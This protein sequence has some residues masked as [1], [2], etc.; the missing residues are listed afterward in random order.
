MGQHVEYKNK[1]EK[2]KSFLKLYEGWTVAAIMK[3]LNITKKV[4][5]DF[6]NKAIM[7]N[8][9][10]DEQAISFRVYEKQAFSE[11][12]ED[13]GTFIKWH[14]GY[15]NLPIKSLEPSELQVVAKAYNLQFK[16]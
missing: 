14:I 15:E 1:K 6:F 12:E 9:V 5:E 7:S 13:Y 8:L 4:Y 2:Y 16:K 11:K 10:E 3:R